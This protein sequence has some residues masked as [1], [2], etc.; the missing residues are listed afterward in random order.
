MKWNKVYVTALGVAA[1]TM[2]TACGAT[3]TT[4]PASSAPAGSSSAAVVELRVQT[5]FTGSDRPAY[6]ALVASFNKSHPNIQVTFDVQ[7]WDTIFQTLP[8]AWASGQGPDVATPSYDPNA[9]F[10]YIEN[11]QVLSLADQGIDGSPFPEA[12]TKAFSSDGTLY[13]VPAN[14]ADMALLYNKDL[15]AEAGID[16]PPATMDELQAAAKKLTKADGSQSGIAL[17]DNGFVLGWNVIQWSNGGD[18]TDEKG[19]SALDSEANKAV[20]ESWSQLIAK[21]KVSPAGLDAPAAENLF[22]AGKAAMVV[23][24]PWLIPTMKKAN[25]NFGVTTM[26]QGSAGPVTALSTVPFMISAKSQHPKEAA[27]FLAWWTGKE[28]Q[29]QFVKDA[30]FPPVRT[31]MAGE[32]TADEYLKPF[33]DGLPSGRLVMPGLAKAGT[34]TSDAYVPLLGELSRGSDVAG[35]VAKASQKINQISGC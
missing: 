21:D 18:I 2:L 27:E 23:G 10:Q 19:C 1:C 31:D 8:A 29:G 30:G 32:V 24:G 35:A 13:A 3:T 33:L 17:P 26:P 20:F 25:V 4:G 34:I 22:S 12:V 28:A 11:G 6:E 5:G 15:F 14:M 16:A 9:I 7:P